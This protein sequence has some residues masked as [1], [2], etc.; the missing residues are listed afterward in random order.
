MLKILLLMSIIGH[1]ICW[2]CDCLL[3]YTEQEQTGYPA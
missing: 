1:G 3:A 2:W